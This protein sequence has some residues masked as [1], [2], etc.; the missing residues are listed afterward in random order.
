MPHVRRAAVFALAL[1]CLLAACPARAEEP[2]PAEALAVP[3]AEQTYRTLKPGSTGDDVLALKRRMYELGYFATEKF[4]AEFNATTQ[5]R[6]KELQRKNG[7]TPDGIATPEVQALI[8]SPEC[9]SRQD[10]APLIRTAMIPGMPEPGGPDAPVPAEDGY[11]AG[12]GEPYVY[13]SR[14]EGVWSYLSH[15]IHVEIRQYSEPSVPR[16]WLVAAVRVRDPALFG[17]MV[18]TRENAKTGV[19][20]T[21][22]SEP[23]DI[24]AEQGAILACSDDFFGHRV[25]NKQK[26]GIVIRDGYVWSGKTRSAAAKVFPPLDVMAVFAD[27]HMQTFDSDAHTAQEYLDMG[28]VTTYA[29][30]PILVRDGGI[31]EDLDKWSATNRDPRMAIGMTADGTILLVDVL[32]RRSDAAGGTF[33]WLAAVMRELGAVEAL[34]LDG[35][36]TTC[37]I[38]MGDMIN[39]TVT[40]KKKDIRSVNS[41]IGVRE[42]APAD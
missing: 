31:C 1:A 19:R 10:P 13:A 21:Y 14:D 34:N 22:L 39:R 32:G 25:L 6:L 42:S 23:G 2:V 15:D 8:F 35:G 41:L 16:I 30:G 24:A 37:M 20:R 26:V 7:L 40:V 9:L 18:N 28:V 36:N 33:P 27:G 3:E 12:D 5:A 29:F 17:P 11:L 38:F 4:S